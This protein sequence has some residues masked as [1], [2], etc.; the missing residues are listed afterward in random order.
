MLVF[1]AI[2]YLLMPPPKKSRTQTPAAG[3]VSVTTAQ[4]GLEIPVIFGT[5]W[6]EGTSVVWYGDV[7]NT[8]I[9]YN[10]GD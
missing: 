5:V 9:R 2:A 10:D 1:T 7:T 6:L 8:P 3:E 4:E